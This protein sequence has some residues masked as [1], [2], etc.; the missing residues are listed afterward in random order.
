M[1]GLKG[2]FCLPEKVSRNKAK[3]H[4]KAVG[5]SDHSVSKGIIPEDSTGKFKQ[6]EI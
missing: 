3:S 1:T 5:L 6:I 2:N 4:F